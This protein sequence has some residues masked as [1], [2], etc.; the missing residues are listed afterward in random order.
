MIQIA[1]KPM[2]FFVYEDTVAKVWQ[3]Q[4]GFV[5]ANVTV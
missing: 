1:T 2:S 4:W 3:R 5:R